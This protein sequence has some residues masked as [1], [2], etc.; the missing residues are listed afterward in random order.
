MNISLTTSSAT[1][2]PKIVRELNSIELENVLI[3][4]TSFSPNVQVIE[5][6]VVIH[7]RMHIAQKI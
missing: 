4:Q 5:L 3:V 7:G 6:D 2:V 1:V